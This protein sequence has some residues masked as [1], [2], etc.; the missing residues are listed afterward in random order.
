MTAALWARGLLDDEYGVRPSD[1]A[2]FRGGLHQPGRVEKM[3][4]RLPDDIAIR[5]I[6]GDATLNAMLREGELDALIS[7]RTPRA[8]LDGDANVTRLFPDYRTAERDYYR[9]TG[10]FPI[11]HVLGIRRRLAEQ[12][13][14]LANAVYDAFCRA[15]D[16][17][18][19]AFSDTS[20]LRVT[21]PWFAAELEETRAIMGEDFWPYGVEANRVTLDRMLDYA[22]RHGTMTRRLAL[23][24]VSRPSPWR[25]LKCSKCMHDFRVWRS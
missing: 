14:W 21:L 8:F 22:C 23:E 1:L 19:A 17:A 10:I 18:V 24:E 9:R 3:A 6:G 2:W 20:A 13:P 12:H 15:R 7:A 25:S 5:D 11:M 4:L 16:I